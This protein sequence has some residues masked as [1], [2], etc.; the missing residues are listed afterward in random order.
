MKELNENEKRIYDF[1]VKQGDSHSQAMQAVEIERKKEESREFYR[2]AY[3][4]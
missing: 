3:E 4:S 1:C 2:F